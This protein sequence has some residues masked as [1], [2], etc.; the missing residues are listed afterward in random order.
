MHFGRAR[1]PFRPSGG[2][3]G[4]NLRSNKW[5][6]RLLFRPF[7]R[8]AAWAWHQLTSRRA[9]PRGTAHSRWKRRVHKHKITGLCQ[10][11][12]IARFLYKRLLRHSF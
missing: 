7:P 1:E 9:P 5:G 11:Q 4:G 6:N 2:G 10:M 3:H 12:I 8:W